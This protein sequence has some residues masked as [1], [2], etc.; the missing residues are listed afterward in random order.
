M[1]QPIAHDIQMISVEGWLAYAYMPT[2]GRDTCERVS[3][4]IE[5]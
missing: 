5:R 3:K 4:S 2:F 1:S